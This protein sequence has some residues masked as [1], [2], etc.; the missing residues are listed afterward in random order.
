[1]VTLKKIF[2]HDSI[3]IGISTR[4]YTANGYD[5]KISCIMGERKATFT[6]LK[7]V[8]Q[9]NIVLNGT[10]EPYLEFNGDVFISDIETFTKQVEDAKELAVY[11]KEHLNEL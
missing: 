2:S 8:Y 7:G 4:T 3:E 11:V 10:D 6:G 1:M 5:I 9:P